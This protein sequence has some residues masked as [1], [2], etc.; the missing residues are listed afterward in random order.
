MWMRKS[1]AALLA[2]GLCAI[3][4]TAA[5]QTP[6]SAPAPPQGNPPTTQARPPATTPAPAQPSGQAP[7]TFRPSEDISVGRKVSFPN[8]I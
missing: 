5:A 4:M 1:K 6:P 8:D 7:R 2:L 3:A